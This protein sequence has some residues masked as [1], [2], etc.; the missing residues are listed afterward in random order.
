MLREKLVEYSTKKRSQVGSMEAEIT[1]LKAR[2]GVENFPDAILVDPILLQDLQTEQANILRSRIAKAVSRLEQVL[3]T[4]E[5]CKAPI[6]AQ[7]DDEEDQDEGEAGLENQQEVATLNTTQPG[8]P[9]TA[10]EPPTAV[11]EGQ[12]APTKFIS[13]NHPAM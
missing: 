1:V 7:Q 13:P 11:Q 10:A 2:V 5:T 8:E 6:P 3:T 4:R 9:S 12:E